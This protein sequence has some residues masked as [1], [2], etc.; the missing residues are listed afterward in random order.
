MV[1][2]AL[3]RHYFNLRHL[4]R[5]ALWIPVT[6]LAGFGV[7]AFLIRPGSGPAVATGAPVPFAQAN[8]VIQQRCAPCHSAHPTQPGFATAP[9]GVRLDTRAEIEAQAQAIERQAVVLKAMPLGN[10]THM[11]E[12]ERDLLARWVRSR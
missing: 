9:K 11:T 1:L 7:V 4:G 10:V 12:A 5:N 8:A 3:V 6:A 2:G